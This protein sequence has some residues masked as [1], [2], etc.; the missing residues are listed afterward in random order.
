MRGV[1]TVSRLPACRPALVGLM[2]LHL[3]GRYPPFEK[4]KKKSTKLK[5]NSFLKDSSQVESSDDK[6]TLF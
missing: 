6:E 2:I 5:I 3:S 1:M 4:K